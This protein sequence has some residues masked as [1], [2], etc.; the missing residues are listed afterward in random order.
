MIVMTLVIVV[1]HFVTSRIDYCNSMLYGISYYNVIAFREFRIVNLVELQI[2]E[3]M[4]IS[5]QFLENCIG[6]LLVRQRIQCNIL[7]TTYKSINNTPPEYQRELVSIR[8][9]SR[10]LGSFSQILLQVSVSRLKSYGNC[11]FSVAAP[12]LWNRLPVS[13][14]NMCSLETFISIL[15]TYLFKVALTDK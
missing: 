15:K 5:P 9:S 11:Q 14:R 7:L 8:K 6:Y 13:N 1:H 10:K 2:L 3:N 12:T 4:I